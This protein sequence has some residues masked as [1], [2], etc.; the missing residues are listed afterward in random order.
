M[1]LIENFK[2]RWS[3]MTTGEKCKAVIS[4]ICD[5][6]GSFLGG[7]LAGKLLSE[8][9]GRIKKFTVKATLLGLGM[10][11]SDLAAGEF[12]QLVDIAAPDKKE[13]DDA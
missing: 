13:E 7:A 6:G 11:A 10:A 5:L 1:K 12:N 4:L 2:K 8:E 9:D 3:N